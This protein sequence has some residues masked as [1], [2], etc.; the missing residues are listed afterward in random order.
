MKN[1]IAK[2]IKPNTK[3]E[4]IDGIKE[5]WN[6]K[7]TVPYC[8]SKIDHLQKVLFTIIRL[9]GKPTGL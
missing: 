6:N 3:Q 8:N 4:L 7:V 9:N 5:F 2:E 1:Y